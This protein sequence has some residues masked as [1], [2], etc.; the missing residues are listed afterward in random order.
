MLCLKYFW[1]Y[2]LHSTAYA[3]PFDLERSSS[4]E[5]PCGGRVLGNHAAKLLNPIG[6]AYSAPKQ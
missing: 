1:K 6:W 2:S 3:T 5:N 4:S